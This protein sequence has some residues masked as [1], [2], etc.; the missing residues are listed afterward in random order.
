MFDGPM[1][2]FARGVN[3]PESDAGASIVMVPS[4]LNVPAVPADRG[5][6]GIVDK[7]WADVK[8]R[9]LTIAFP[10]GGVSPGGAF[11][12]APRFGSAFLSVFSCGMLDNAGV[13]FDR[14][15]VAGATALAACVL[16]YGIGSANQKV[17]LD[18]RPGSYNVPACEWARASI[19]LWGTD[20]NSVGVQSYA[21]AAA[22]A[23]GSIE[24]QHPPTVTAVGFLAAGVAR[25]FRVP[26][27]ARAFEVEN[28]DDSV[29]P[30]LTVG[31]TGDTESAVRN[32]ASGAF[33]PAWS[34]LDCPR[35]GELFTLVSDVDTTARLTFY[36][37]L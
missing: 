14:S 28:V 23:S 18:W 1:A 19:L 27:N 16:E 26:A 37:S 6:Y 35:P 31:S 15:G 3:T 30:V 4:L 29:T 2:P 24:G 12:P 22:L 34:P 33:L 7:R 11:P 25:T 9:N 8:P 5:T 21:A 17:W 20:W 36:L 10:A 13:S 32:Y